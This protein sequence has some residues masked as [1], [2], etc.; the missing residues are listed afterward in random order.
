[1][2]LHPPTF[3]A[4]PGGAWRITDQNSQEA[5]DLFRVWIVLIGNIIYHLRSIPLSHPANTCLQYQPCN[6]HLQVL[7]TIPPTKKQ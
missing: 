1:M 3:T 4:R 2:G 6:A 5:A 7:A